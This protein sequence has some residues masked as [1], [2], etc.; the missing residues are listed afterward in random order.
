M[1]KPKAESPAPQSALAEARTSEALVA[2]CEQSRTALYVEFMEYLF[3]EAV[4]DSKKL[5]EKPITV[6]RF[7][8]VKADEMVLST[9]ADLLLREVIAFS[10]PKEKEFSLVP[11]LAEELERARQKYLNA[12][13]PAPP[14]RRTKKPSE[15]LS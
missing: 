15:R 3:A 14:I 4:R 6:E 7:M 2:P 8:E 11:R 13:K 1:K 9:F 10:N 12:K 5:R